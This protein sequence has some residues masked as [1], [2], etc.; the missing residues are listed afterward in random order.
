V[1]ARCF[2]CWAGGC[3]ARFVHSVFFAAGSTP[4]GRKRG[5]VVSVEKGIAVPFTRARRRR[6]RRPGCTRLRTPGR[7]AGYVSGEGAP[8]VSAGTRRRRSAGPGF[9][10]GTGSQRYGRSVR[11]HA[12]HVKARSNCATRTRSAWPQSQ[13]TMK[14]SIARH[15]ATA[16]ASR[17]GRAR[18]T[19]RFS[20][21]TSRREVETYHRDSRG[22]MPKTA[23]AV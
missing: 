19:G 6:R 12:R 7:G 4:K 20:R 10:T 13:R 15:D 3:A 23:I 17:H 21:D 9:G 2:L 11:P 8:P 1:R 22:R 5:R 14:S 18:L 16:G